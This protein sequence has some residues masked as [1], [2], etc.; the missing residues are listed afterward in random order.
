MMQS[1]DDNEIGRNGALCPYLGFS[2][3]PDTALSFPSS[4]NW[5]FHCK[6]IAPVSIDHQ[7]RNCLS[8]KYSDCPIFASDGSLPL[9]ASI[10]GD[11]GSKKKIN[12]WI[13]GVII[14]G[15]VIIGIVA[16]SII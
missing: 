7:E 12:L 13:I 5:C 6:P 15:L 14:I 9:P 3:D 8:E 2:D 11:Y 4:M 16:L 1:S 10:R